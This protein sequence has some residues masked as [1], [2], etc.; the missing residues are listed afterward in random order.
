MIL[1]RVKNPN[2]FLLTYGGNWFLLSVIIISLTGKVVD[3]K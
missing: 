2:K 1:K 3:P